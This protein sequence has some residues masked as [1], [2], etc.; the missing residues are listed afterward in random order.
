[1]SGWENIIL[2]TVKACALVLIVDTV[3]HGSES[4]RQP[5][6]L[7][8][9][10]SEE[11]HRLILTDT[12]PHLGSRPHRKSSVLCRHRIL[13]AGSHINAMSRIQAR[14]NHVFAYLWKV[15]HRMM[16]SF[17]GAVAVFKNGL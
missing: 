17:I 2:A 15:T 1:M 4:I 5:A 16:M 13:E 9:A 10:K 8:A 3:Q 7:E 12:R 11:K 14:G 6:E